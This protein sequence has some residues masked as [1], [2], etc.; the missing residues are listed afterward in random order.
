[1]SFAT[2]GFIVRVRIVRLPPEERRGSYEVDLRPYQVGGVY[3]VGPRIAEYLIVMG[4][5]EPESRQ[6]QAADWN[7][8]DRDNK[9]NKPNKK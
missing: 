3:E 7:R 6:E 1:V 9:N 5:A 4:F 2:S 8:T